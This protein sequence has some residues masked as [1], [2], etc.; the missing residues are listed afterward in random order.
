MQLVLGVVGLGIL[1]FQYRKRYSPVQQHTRYSRASA[2]VKRGVSKTST[3]ECGS[4]VSAEVFSRCA[5]YSDFFPFWQC[6]FAVLRGYW[7]KYAVFYVSV[8]HVLEWRRKTA[9]VEC[10]FAG[11]AKIFY[12]G[13][14]SE[15]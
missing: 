9:T 4:P 12:M 14:N 10:G 11:S 1:L 15:N 3:V 13:V 8:S 7:G 5:H 6:F 2:S